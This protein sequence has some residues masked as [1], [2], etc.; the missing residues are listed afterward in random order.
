MNACTQP[1]LMLAIQAC[2][3]DAKSNLFRNINDVADAM[4]TKPTRD[5]VYKWVELGR[6][7]LAEIAEF[8][9]ACNASHISAYLAACRGHLLVK[10]PVAEGLPQIEFARIQC[11]VAKAILATSTALVDVAQTQ[12]AVDAI[13]VAIHGLVTVRTQLSTGAVK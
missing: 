10:E 1:N 12:D 3:N 8:E 2:L 11:Q 5:A 9:R 13:A 7:P 6:M 4:Q